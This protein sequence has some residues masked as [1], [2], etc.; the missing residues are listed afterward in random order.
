[1]N[2]FCESSKNLL[3]FTLIVFAL[4][5]TKIYIKIFWSWTHMHLT[6]G[7]ESTENNERGKS[8]KGKVQLAI[9][10]HEKALEMFP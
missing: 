3:Y 1:M 6:K 10:S 7:P 8:G 2:F 4:I 5:L 9:R